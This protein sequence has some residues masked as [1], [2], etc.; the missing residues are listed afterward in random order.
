VAGFACV[1]EDGCNLWLGDPDCDAAHQVI[2]DWLGKRVARFLTGEESVISSVK[3]NI[4][5]AIA[6]VVGQEHKFAME[7]F[8]FP[9]NAFHPLRRISQSDIDIVWIHFGQT[10]NDDLLFLQEVKTTSLPN[11]KLADGLVVDYEKLFG[12][13][14]EFTLHTRL[15]SIK[16]ILEYQHK[17][18]ELCQRVT[19]LAGKSPQTS[20]KVSLLP[21][22]VHER[23]NASPVTKMLAVREML[24]GRGWDSKGIELWAIGLSNLE[25]RL[26]RLALGAR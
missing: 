20:P 10:R 4:G 13:N 2:L 23:T 9:A 8:P 12:T 26:I 18:P 11:L 21:T 24:I 16:N 25:D 22:L 5:E 14:V 7:D 3:G 6:F 17:K 15:S 1:D 19:Y